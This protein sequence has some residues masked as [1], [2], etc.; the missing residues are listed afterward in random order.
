M[1]VHHHA[2]SQNDLHVLKR[3]SWNNIPGTKLGI[4]QRLHRGHL[5]MVNIGLL[6][7]T[8][9]FYA[10]ESRKRVLLRTRE[11]LYNESF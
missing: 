1:N 3:T 6:S 5:R 2:I 7:V 10:R 4:S 11:R 8:Y 9:R